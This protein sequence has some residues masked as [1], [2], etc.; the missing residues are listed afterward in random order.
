VPVVLLLAIVAVL[1]AVFFAA[2]GRGGEL[3]Y[4]P[5]DHAPLDL[6]PVSAT[7]VAL[8][9][10]PTAL[11]G[12]NI[13]VTDEALDRIARA[14]RDRDVTIAYLQQ[15]LADLDQEPASGGRSV[16]TRPDLPALPDPD[17]RPAP[18]GLPAR[19]V[20]RSP[21]AQE[22]TQDLLDLLD[23]G[24]SRAAQEPETPADDLAAWDDP[25]TCDEPAVPGEPAAAEG[26]TD[27]ADA[28]DPDEDAAPAEPPAP[29]D[30]TAS[31]DEAASAGSHASG[32]PAPGEDAVP[33]TDGETLAPEEQ[34]R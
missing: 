23:V 11:W 18:S 19:P 2:T 24:G 28:G 3:S 30:V 17:A 26:F 34:S 21:G 25:A 12:Y 10:P 29:G 9:R 13:Q 33:A 16:L 7:D 32:E 15:Q 5:A 14:M 1:V 8:L 6:G 31:G 27:R 4:E 20:P 22:D